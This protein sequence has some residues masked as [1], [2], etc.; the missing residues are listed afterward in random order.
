MEVM[1]QKVDLKKEFPMYYRAGKR[2]ET[3]DVEESEF[4]SL[5][6]MGAPEGNL[7]MDS[8]AA[9][10]AVAYVV[11]KGYQQ[12]GLDFVVP[13]LEC[14]WWVE[15]DLSFDETPRK[16]WFWEL[17]IRMPGFVGAKQVDDCIAEVIQKK[18]ISLANEVYLKN[19]AEGKSVQI[20]HIGSYEE[21]K[22][23]IDKLLEYVANEGLEICGHHHEVYISDPRKTPAEKLKT[24][25][26]YAVKNKY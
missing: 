24:I 5:S 12:I 20:M 25:L 2:P 19:F 3:I 9:I 23:S 1:A 15:S 11:K 4:L 8:I 26:R 13:K 14:F 18:N 17:L 22:P 21:E 16:E 7:F 10:Y 6:G